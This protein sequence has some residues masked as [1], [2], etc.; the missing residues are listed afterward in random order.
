MVKPRE[1]GVDSSHRR[2]CAFCGEHFDGPEFWSF[3]LQRNSK[4]LSCMRCDNINHFVQPDRHNA[5]GL[6]FLSIVMLVSLLPVMAGLIWVA[7]FYLAYVDVLWLWAPIGA[8]ILSMALIRV[9]LK[10]Y[11]WHFYKVQD[12]SFE[13]KMDFSS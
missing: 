10:I 2:Q 12:S 6:I 8:T 4:T 3:L 5:V 9:A 1:I 7:A 13:L 11:K